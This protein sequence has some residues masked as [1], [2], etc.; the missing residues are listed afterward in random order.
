M[1]HK[2]SASTHA[3]N[4]NKL[5]GK[6]LIY[7]TDYYTKHQKHTKQFFEHDSSLCIVFFQQSRALH[8]EMNPFLL[9][10]AGVLNVFNKLYIVL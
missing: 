4:G 10:S 7:L 2:T 6:S 8:M 3:Y 9:S 5:A 1:E